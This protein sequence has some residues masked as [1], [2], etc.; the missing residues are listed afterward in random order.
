MLDT[1][2]NATW[3]VNLAESIDRLLTIDITGRGVIAGL[4]NAA[5]RE[6]G[7]QPL[8]YLAARTLV[9]Q[10]KKGDRVIIATGMVIQPW[11]CPEQDGPVGAATLARALVL[12]LAAKPVLVTEPAFVPVLETCLKAAGLNICPLERLAELPTSAA[13]VGFPI[14]AVEAERVSGEL[15]AQLEPRVLISIERAGANEF[16]EYHGAV[17]KNLSAWSAKID[18]L[19]EEAKARGGLTIGIGDGGNEL[20]CGLIRSAVIDQV[21]LAAKCKCP[22]Q[23]SIV[24]RFVPDVLLMTCISNWGAYGIEALLAAIVGDPIVLH[25]AELE[26]RVQ[27]WAAMAG[28]NNDGPG[29]LEPG[30][31]AVPPLIHCHLIEMLAFLVKTGSDPGRLYRVPRYRWL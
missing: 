11:R 9:E 22:C 25:D 19:F 2:Q 14:D 24:P 20:G 13:V 3:L 27:E 10:V 16:G 31:D 1:E 21:P 7:G 12:G 26:R 8:T 4:Y 18:L 23:G 29:L 15:L 28:A 6:Q 30:V 17:G 5:R